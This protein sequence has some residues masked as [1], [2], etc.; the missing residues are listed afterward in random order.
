M[1][2]L[3][4]VAFVIQGRTALDY[5]TIAHHIVAIVTF[6]QTLYFMDFAV[7]FGV[8]LLVIEISTIFMNIRWLLFEHGYGQSTAYAINA[9]FLFFFFILTRMIYQPYILILCS[10]YI[11][12]EYGKKGVG[13][14]KAFV[15]SELVVMVALSMV[16]N[17]YW[18]WLMCKMIC[19]VIGKAL[20]KPADDIEKVELIKADSLKAEQDA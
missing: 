11:Y 8:M 4:H 20:K 9:L 18:F 14:Y 1:V 2:D 3:F 10:G 15:I 6:Y 19:R 17:T 12:D 5:Q 16:L 13:Y 7:V